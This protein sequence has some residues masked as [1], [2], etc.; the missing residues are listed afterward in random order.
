M[1]ICDA[2]QLDV[3]FGALANKT[4]RTIVTT[5]AGKECTVLELAGKFRMSQPAVTK[6]LNVLEGAGIITRKK[7][8]RYREC[9]IVPGA[10][11]DASAWIERCKTYWEDGFKSLEKYLEEEQEE[12]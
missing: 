7:A 3:L 1:V 4:R 9:V 8:G 2:P 12:A 11:D 10:L 5:L 6:H